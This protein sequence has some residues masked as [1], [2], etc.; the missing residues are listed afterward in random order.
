MET[1]H[2]A[3]LIQQWED[4]EQLCNAARNPLSKLRIACR[5]VFGDLKTTET[6]VG[7]EI[8]RQLREIKEFQCPLCR[9]AVGAECF[10][11][12]LGQC[13]RCRFPHTM[14]M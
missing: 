7:G 13:P 1:K 8:A 2:A 11:S 4:F 5:I 3:A 9:A 12:C 14:L 6:T 10:A